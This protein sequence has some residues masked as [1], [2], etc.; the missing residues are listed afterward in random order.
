VLSARR[1]TVPLSGNIP[2]GQLAAGVLSSTAVS[3]AAVGPPSEHNTSP[4]SARLRSRWALQSLA[5]LV[6]ADTMRDA[7]RTVAN[8]TADLM[9]LTLFD[10]LRS[11]PDPGKDVTTVPRAEACGAA[12]HDLAQPLPGTITIR[13]S[14][15]RLP[16]LTCR[17]RRQRARAS[18][19][20]SNSPNLSR[21]P[22]ALSSLS[23]IVPS[24]NAARLRVCRFHSESMDSFSRS[25][26]HA[27]L[28]S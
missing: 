10:R 27:D 12:V 11:Q 14:S 25:S 5:L 26:K 20:S 19:A 21:S 16:N 23:D 24:V 17:P 9:L 8:V 22:T 28:L 1:A 13:I 4:R 15:A 2:I 18:G 3:V 7:F 6:I